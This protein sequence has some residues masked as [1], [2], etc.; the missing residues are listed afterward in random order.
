MKHFRIIAICWLAFLSGFIG[1]LYVY[2]NRVW[3]YQP[4]KE[5]KDF[6]SG[7]PEENVPLEKK[8]INDLNLKPSRYIK[9]VNL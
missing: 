3:P 2:D 5:I 7:H 9:T 4:L 8:I 1:G 6:I